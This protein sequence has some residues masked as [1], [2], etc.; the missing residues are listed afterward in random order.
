MLLN[1]Y[2]YAHR[3]ALVTADVEKVEQVEMLFAFITIYMYRR[4]CCGILVP[5]RP[6]AKRRRQLILSARHPQTLSIF[7]QQQ[8]RVEKTDFEP[9]RKNSIVKRA[10]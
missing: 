5:G 2:A 9:E 4:H 1:T 7:T 8:P 6:A 3:R 10:V